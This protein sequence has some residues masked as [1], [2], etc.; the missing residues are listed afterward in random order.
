M[1]TVYII[2]VGVAAVKNWKS[3]NSPKVFRSIKRNHGTVFSEYSL[4]SH[5]NRNSFTKLS[6]CIKNLFLL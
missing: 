3:Q 4:I 2:I 1:M 5:S 6:N